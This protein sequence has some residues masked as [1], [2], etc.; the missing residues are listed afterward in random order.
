MANPYGIDDKVRDIETELKKRKI[1]IKRVRAGLFYSK[2]CFVDG[3]GVEAKKPMP[4]S[5]G[6]LTTATHDNDAIKVFNQFKGANDL[7][8][9]TVEEAECLFMKMEA[10]AMHTLNFD[11]QIMGKYSPEQLEQSLMKQ[12]ESTGNNGFAY[13]PE[14]EIVSVI[15]YLYTSLTK[16]EESKKYYEKNKAIYDRYFKL[17]ARKIKQTQQEADPEMKA[18]Y[19]KPSKSA[20]EKQKSSG[21]G[22]HPYQNL[23]APKFSKPPEPDE[24]QPQ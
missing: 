6:K 20:Y 13:M 22:F 9:Y 11:K 3:N 2:W 17:L 21:K 16:G 12:I 10:L 14:E 19:E 4:N 24:P 8:G 15:C 5:S 18:Y 23:R 1:S 7:S